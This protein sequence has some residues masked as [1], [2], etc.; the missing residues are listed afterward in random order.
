[1]LAALPVIRTPK[2]AFGSC[3]APSAF[4]PI[5]LPAMMLPDV[6]EPWTWTPSGGRDPG[7][8]PAPPMVLFDARLEQHAVAPLGTA[9]V[10][11]ALVPDNSPGLRRRC[12]RSRFPL[13]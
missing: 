11:L 7:T 3:V 12:S 1:M 5:Q 13:D 9:T 8:S 10:P 2:K 6:V 4:K